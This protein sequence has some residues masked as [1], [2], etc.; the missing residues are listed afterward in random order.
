MASGPSSLSVSPDHAS[1]HQ[2]LASEFSKAC[3]QVTV[4]KKAVIDEQAV[5]SQLRIELNEK[6]RA[7]RKYQLEIDGLVFHNQQLTKRVE[8]LQEEIIEKETKKKGFRTNKSHDGVKEMNLVLNEELASKIEENALLHTKL[9]GLESEHEAELNELRS[10]VAQLQSQI[11]SRNHVSGV[12]EDAQS[13]ELTK[14]REDKIRLELRLHNQGQELTA[15]KLETRR[16][17]SLLANLTADFETKNELLDR[18]L[19]DKLPFLDVESREKN[20]LN[21]PAH[22]Q[23][24]VRWCKNFME[25]ILTNCQNAALALS[26]FYTQFERRSQCSASLGSA[27]F[28]MLLNQCALKAKRLHGDCQTWSDDCKKSSGFT[29]WLLPS[30]VSSLSTLKDLDHRQ[31]LL[32]PVLCR[33]MDSRDTVFHDGKTANCMFLSSFKKLCSALSKTFSQE[34]KIGDNGYLNLETLERFHLN[35]IDLSTA[36]KDMSRCFDEMV[37]AESGN[38]EDLDATNEM[39]LKALVSLMTHIHKLS[40]SLQDTLSVVRSDKKI[41]DFLSL[42]PHPEVDQLRQKTVKYLTSI[43]ID[44]KSEGPE[45]AEGKRLPATAQAVNTAVTEEIE[46]LKKRVATVEQM[47]EHWRL[48]CHLLEKKHNRDLEKLKCLQSGAVAL[49]SA[50]AEAKTKVRLF[51]VEPEV[52]EKEILDYYRKRLELFVTQH[53]TLD[54]KCSSFESE[55]NF[56]RERLLLCEV[57]RKTLEEKVEEDREHKAQLREE[58]DTT[59]KNY[60]DQLSLMSEHLA[61]LNDRLTRQTD[62]I[63]ELRAEMSSSKILRVIFSVILCIPSSLAMRAIEP[64]L[65]A[66][67]VRERRWK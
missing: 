57:E 65:P 58:L 3:A 26:E 6:D 59:S 40:I 31:A 47:K 29:L 46:K 7:L 49:D 67:Y 23:K 10:C 24:L 34:T 11:G 5:S 18:I 53:L 16:V 17:E 27:E 14:M 42:T 51:D 50:E 61:Q 52:R 62:E 33:F 2:R 1:K 56:L 28:S 22:D 32:L 55:M 9:A 36:A 15:S 38:S 48:E 41:L 66:P 60:E 44:V 64:I 35:A 25:A 39:V 63:E 13:K 20:S 54:S 45:C 43:A 19:A 4:L 37:S 30:A 8:L 12:L 21:V